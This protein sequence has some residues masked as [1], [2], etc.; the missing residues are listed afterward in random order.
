MEGK[1]LSESHLIL[2]TDKTILDYWKWGHSVV[3]DNT[4]RGVFAEFLVGS[5]L[6]A[7]EQ[8][9]IEWENTDIQYRSKIVGIYSVM[10]TIKSK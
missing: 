10:E 1:F 7:L 8:P 5:A 6:D 9:R 3:L 4:A 2:G